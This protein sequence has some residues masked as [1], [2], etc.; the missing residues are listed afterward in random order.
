MEAHR[1]LGDMYS[2]GIGCNKDQFLAM[3]HYRLAAQ[4]GEQIAV[5]RLKQ[6]I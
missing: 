4:Q 3:E 2:F 5:S 6:S 1:K